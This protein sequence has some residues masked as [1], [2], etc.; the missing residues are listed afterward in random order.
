MSW[1]QKWQPTPVFLPRESHEQRSLVGQ[2]SVRWQRI[3]CD[4]S[5]LAWRLLSKPKVVGW[6]HEL[7]RHSLSKLQE[8]VK[9]REAWH[10][11]DH[12]VTKSCTQLSDWTTATTPVIYFGSKRC[13]TEINNTKVEYMLVLDGK[14]KIYEIA[15]RS[16]SESHSVVSDSLWPCG[17]SCPWNSPGQNTGVRSLSLFQGIFQTQGLNPGLLHR[18]QILY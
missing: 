1:R 3:G 16:E 8:I 17:L 10:A 7:S 2:K 15:N 18:R 6:H 13:L 4:W 5:A 11:A 14:R 12:R 9:D